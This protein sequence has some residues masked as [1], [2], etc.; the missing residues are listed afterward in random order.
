MVPGAASLSWSEK[1]C[2]P[3]RA[4]AD[5]LL[6][7]AFGKSAIAVDELQWI[8]TAPPYWSLRLVEGGRRVVVGR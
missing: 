4:S 2:Q 5:K 1:D 3:K 7:K 8:P 6:K